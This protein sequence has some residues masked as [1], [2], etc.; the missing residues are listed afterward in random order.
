MD[1]DFEEINSALI[2][3]PHFTRLDAAAAPG[4]RDRV[5]AR[6]GGRRLVVLAMSAI[7]FMDSSGLGSLV[8]LLKLLPAG[9]VLR[10]AEVKP[11]VQTV[12]RLTRLDAVMRAFPSIDQAVA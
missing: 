7:D 12:L 5:A 11:A 6:L 10:L 8:A 9:G 1:I 3:R 4:F 2:I